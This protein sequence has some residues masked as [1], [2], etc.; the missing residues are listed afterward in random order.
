[1]QVFI[2]AP[3]IPFARRL[4][5]NDQPPRIKPCPPAFKGSQLT[6]FTSRS[7]KVKHHSI[8]DWLLAQA[9]DAGIEGA[10]V[11]SCSEGVGGD[12]HYHAARFFELADEPVAVTV[13]ADDR[14][15]DALLSVL[16]KAGVK[17]FY[18]RTPVEYG[19]IGVVESN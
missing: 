4:A 3:N 17:L 11:V 16:D 10:T 14:E 18:T 8:I 2:V 9:K 5:V 12:G 15:I 13:A 1:M 19:T 7:Q 6:V